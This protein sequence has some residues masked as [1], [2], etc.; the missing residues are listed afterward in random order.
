M[1]AFKNIIFL[2]T[3]LLIATPVLAAD[4]VVVI[5]NSANTQELS[6]ED[7]KNIYSDNI[8]AWQSGTR[9]KLYNTPTNS[10]VRE[11]F[12][13]EIL[14][15]SALQAAATES[16]KRITNTLKNPP[17]TKRERLIAASVAKKT[18]AIGYVSKEVADKRSG[19]RVI[20]TITE[21]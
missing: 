17:D 15:L 13:Q 7:I 11:I 4:V 19:I 10:Y 12:S 20:F 9:I 5:V 16:N 8:T 14:E 18:N 2:F 21:E 3:T 6:Q 1:K